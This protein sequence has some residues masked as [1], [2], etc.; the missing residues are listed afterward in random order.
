MSDVQLYAVEEDGVR[1]LPVPP[2]ITD[3]TGLYGGLELGVY[4][5][6]RTFDHDKFLY[7]ENHIA[8]TVSSMRLLGWDY[9]LDEGRLRQALHEV[10]VAYPLPEARVR[11]DVLAAAPAHLGTT[12][13]E[14]IGLIPFPP[15]PPRFYK[16][17]VKVALAADLHRKTPLAK[18]ATFAQMRQL[19]QRSP[20]I[21]EHLLISPAEEIL[22]GMGMN[23]YGVMDGVLH[24]AGKGVLAGITRKIILDLAADLQIPV[25]LTAVHVSQL[26]QL[27]EA[28][29]S[30]SSR[31]LLPVVQIGD[32]IVGDGRPGPICRRLLKAYNSF[33]SRQIKMAVE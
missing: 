1:P 14:L 11:F 16:T 10:C 25:S 28:A 32:A 21:Y 31:A 20:D 30:S 23:F 27:Q 3:F 9:L 7:L 33:V 2:H 5:A 6:L 19:V 22:E 15:I 4:S 13:R 18:T 29:L 24:T 17:G 12:S 8:R 26:P